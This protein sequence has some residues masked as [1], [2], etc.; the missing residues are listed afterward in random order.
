MARVWLMGSRLVVMY[1][2]ISLVYTKAGEHEA[3]DQG[4]RV[5]EQRLQ[6]TASGGGNLAFGGVVNG[7]SQGL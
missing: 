3:S 1:R 2:M 7:E 6:I 5:L 4:K